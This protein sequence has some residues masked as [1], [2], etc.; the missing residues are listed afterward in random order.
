MPL[1][2]QQIRDS[3]SI[4]EQKIHDKLLVYLDNAA[5]TQKPLIVVNTIYK[6]YTVKNSNIHRGVYYISQ[7]A[8]E[9]YE[10]AREIIQKFIN[11]KYSHEIIFTRGT[12]ES[13]NL[14]ATSFGKEFIKEDD[15]IITTIME[16]H[17][18]FVPWQALCNEK[19][20][21]LK[22][23]DIDN[24]GNINIQQLKNSITNKTKLIAV[25]HI[26]NVLGTINNIK[27]IITEAHKLNIPVL[28]D[29]AQSIAHQQINVQELDCDFFCFSGHKIYGPTGIGILY[30]KEKYLDKMPPYQ[31]GGE[32][33][34][35][36]SIEKTTFNSLPFKF[37]AGTSHIAGAIGL[38]SAINYFKSIGIDKIIEHEH[39]LLQYATQKLTTIDN[40]HI[41]GNSQNKASVISFN[42]KPFHH[43]DI[44]TL[45][46][47]FG[48]AVRTGHFC[49]QPLMTRFNVN[50]MSRISFAIYNTFE[51]IDYTVDALKKVT[52]ML[53]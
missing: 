18:N 6:F 41:Y 34:N 40:L 26:S 13:I 19:H 25:T 44:G 24:D 7:E 42:I 8:T 21:K 47:K 28:I 37:E 29:G 14:V 50:G 35:S 49:A 46:D 23:I 12:T 11:A 38:A 53:K 48:I 51:E 10:K 36:V 39:N 27:E 52:Q 33:I 9:A 31:Y 30:G 45:L 4:L 17:S 1:N 3:F 20:A 22:V 2:I 32:M 5:T 43:Y 16:H 15:E